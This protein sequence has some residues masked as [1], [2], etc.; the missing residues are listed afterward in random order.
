M[1]PIAFEELE[2]LGL[3]E[4][5]G[6]GEITGFQID[7]RRIGG[8]DLFVAI[9]GGRE[10][11]GDG[12]RS[13]RRHARAESRVR[14][15]GGD[16]A[17]AAR[18]QPRPL[19]RRH[20]LD[21]QDVDEGHPG[22]TLLGGGADGVDGGEL[23]RRAR[24]AADARPARA[25]DRDLHRRDGDARLRADRRSL[26]HRAAARRR[27]QRRRPR[28]S[29]ARRLGGGCRALE[30]G[31]RRRPAA[32][33]DRRRAGVGRP[34]T[35]PAERH[36]DPARAAGRRRAARGRRPR[37]LR[38]APDPLPAHVAPPGAERAHRPDGL[39]GDGP[40]ARQARGGCGARAALEVARRGA[41]AARRRLRR[42]RRV[43]REPDVDGGRAAASR[44]AGSGPPAPRHPRRH[45]RAR[46]PCRAASPRDRRACGRARNRG[47]GGRRPRAR[48]PAPTPGSRMRRSALAAARRL[49][50]PGDAVL[51]KAS[52]SVALEGIAPTLANDTP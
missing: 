23:Q 4:L 36:R 19:R 24:R 8:G 46:R 28:P 50:Q 49:V 34:G 48:I 51:V 13:W 47:A 26:R 18:P 27:D 32:G 14:R 2:A 35:A 33:R 17:D 5:H 15:D 37:R 1:I 41:A 43:Q 16:R 12:A 21:R 30:G 3:G 20:R 45:G 7:S 9:G 11:V 31:A 42:Q 22:G 38:R 40:A 52:R 6:S 44:R 10:F 25:G 29:R 39:R